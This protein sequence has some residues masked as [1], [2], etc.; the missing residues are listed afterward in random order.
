MAAG[1]PELAEVIVVDDGSGDGTAAIAEGFAGVRVI[2][3]PKNGGKTRAM[4]TGI[5]AAQSSHLLFLDS[6]LEGLQRSDITALIAPVAAGRASASLSLRRNAPRPWHWLGIDYISGERVIARASLPT[7]LS[8]F[9]RLPGFGFEVALNRIWVARGNPIAVVPWPV[10]RSPLKAEKA[11]WRAGIKADIG[12][13]RDILRTVG[14]REV[15]TQITTLR[16]LSRVNA[17]SQS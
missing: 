3:Q 15:V 5:K 14:L 13:I 17:A 7:D 4:L 8:T 9:E 16:R 11:G 1:H 6:D 2:R 12:M 10:V